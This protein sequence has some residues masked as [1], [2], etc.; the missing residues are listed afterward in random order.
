MIP[1]SRGLLFWHKHMKKQGL[2]SGFGVGL[3][4]LSDGLGDMF[5]WFGGRFGTM[6]GSVWDGT[7]IVFC[8]PPPAARPALL[9]ADAGPY[10]AGQKSVHTF[11][12]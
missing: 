11:Y 10:K 2:G 4:L 12:M 6:L 3:G 8:M 7:G 1:A 5:M 9:S